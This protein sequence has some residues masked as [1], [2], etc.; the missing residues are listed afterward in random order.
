MLKIRGNGFLFSVLILSV[1]VF[2]NTAHSQGLD[3]QNDK[4]GKLAFVI[5]NSAYTSLGNLP[6]ATNDAQD[7]AKKLHQLNVDTILAENL[8]E[9][10][11]LALLKSKESLIAEA[12]AVLFFYAGHGYQF[13]GQ[14]YIVPVSA[15]FGS[16]DDLANNAIRLNTIIDQLQDRERPTLI[17][18]DACRNNPLATGDTDNDYAA[19]LAQLEAGDS[20]FIAFATQPGNVTADG[21][22]RN[23]PF[24]EALLEHIDR[25]GLSISDLMIEVRK[26]VEQITLGRQTPWEQSSL[27]QQ[28]YFTDD[29][30]IEPF[31]LANNF[32]AIM[33]DPV[34]REEMKIRLDSSDP[35]SLHQF[36][37][38]HSGA[39]VSADRSVEEDPQNS[40]VSTEVE[41]PQLKIT[42]VD[43]HLE[44]PS[45]PVIENDI[46][47][48]LTGLFVDT[49]QN[50]GGAIDNKN[51]TRRVQTELARLGCYRLEI[52][53][54]WG[55]GSKAAL[56]DYHRR[57]HLSSTSNAPSIDLLTKLFLDTGRICPEPRRKK[58]VVKT[59][60]RAH[61]K[62]AA[63]RSSSRP[64]KSKR[65]SSRSGKKIRKKP[66]VLPPDISAGVGIGGIF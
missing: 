10:E 56:A 47:S 17:F 42:A 50:N 3:S 11:F 43:P 52:D 34:L 44:R 39:V 45:R 57:K 20:T 60:N 30:E 16:E 36:I 51:I 53:G 32:A 14:N 64:S 19:G 26:S 12:E 18:L 63:S 46:A 24:T 40:R 66:A 55:K 7:L 6:N 13:K 22:G 41:A 49:K 31:V 4:P 38:R 27:R 37:L 54:L 23:S 9:E 15:K 25:P 48:G 28:F 5:G 59:S 1:L 62:R 33:Q 61:K 65:R 8:N 58:P 2:S 35:N 29:V 21:L